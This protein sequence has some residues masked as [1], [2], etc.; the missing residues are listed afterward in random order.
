MG[1]LPDRHLGYRRVP[2]DTAILP[3]FGRIVKTADRIGSGGAGVDRPSVAIIG[4]G[5]A[6]LACA[7]MLTK[8]GFA[9]EVF[10]KGRRPGGRIATRR[11][12]FGCFDHGAQ[13]FT[14]NDPHLRAWTE[15]GKAAGK[16][17]RWDGALAAAGDGRVQPASGAEQR[18]VGVPG[19]SAVAA[20]LAAGL[21]IRSELRIVR[22]VRAGDAWRLHGH[23]GAAVGNANI[24]IIAVPAPQAVELLSAIPR[25]A[26]RAAEAVMLPCWA[27]M[28]GYAMPLPLPFDGAFINGG[29]LSWICRNT[30][31][32][33]RA[34]DEAWVVQASPDWSRDHLEDDAVSICE[35]LR[36]AFAKATGVERPAPVFMAAHRWRYARVATPLGMPCLFDDDLRIGACG[37]WCLGA[38]IEAAFRSGQAMAETILAHQGIMVAAGRPG[39]R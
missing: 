20:H 16:L 11:T 13:Y 8:Q 34:G 35:A 15:E 27:A 2:G 14:A 33:G 28:L 4:A 7:A 6:G 26:G 3:G 23:D 38:N 36:E 10:D 1:N 22:L 39:S 37:D 21:A 31:K 25:L 24:V 5:M 18:W 19:M 12:P 17:G 9:V 30:S 29:P 32:P